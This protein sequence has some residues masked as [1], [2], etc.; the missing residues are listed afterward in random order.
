M[1]V[2]VYSMTEVES[3]TREVIS[4][5]EE[6]I[7]K[8]VGSIHVFPV[9]Y[10]NYPDGV[11]VQGSSPKINRKYGFAFTC[12]GHIAET[13]PVIPSLA[14][15]E[16]HYHYGVLV[17]GGRSVLITQDGIEMEVKNKFLPSGLLETF[18]NL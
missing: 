12:D 15:T 11:H 8:I 14:G 13:H 3:V 6:D 17:L 10:R 4:Y 16:A 5:I 2:I 1:E 9:Q 18:T 7:P